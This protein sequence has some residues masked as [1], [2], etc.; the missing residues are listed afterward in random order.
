MLCM[1]LRSGKIMFFHIKITTFNNI[2]KTTLNVLLIV[3][4]ESIKNPSIRANHIFFFLWNTFSIQNR[5]KIS[6]IPCIFHYPINNLLYQII[7]PIYFLFQ[8]YLS[9]H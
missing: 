4:A 6:S 1:T 9:H 8:T 2:I 5:I 7:C 3:A